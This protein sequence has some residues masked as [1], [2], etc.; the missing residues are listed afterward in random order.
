MSNI[1]K[2]DLIFLSVS[3]LNIA[4]LY[5]II[6]SFFHIKTVSG[7]TSS[8]SIVAKIFSVIFNLVLAF[9]VFWAVALGLWV[10]SADGLFVK[11][12][13]IY[14]SDFI[15]GMILIETSIFLPYGL[16]FILHKLWYQKTGLS[17]WWIFPDI[18]IGV[19]VF[20]VCI[21]VIIAGDYINDWSTLPWK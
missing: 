16:N 18:I 6:K 12:D 17:K 9:C 8:W 3:A 19:V 4:A 10:I 1:F 11:G 13:N 7:K 15:T 21:V 20:A 5:F 14:I 2:T